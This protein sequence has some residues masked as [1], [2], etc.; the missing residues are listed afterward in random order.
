MP[1]YVCS[2]YM[3]LHKH[4][5]CVTSEMHRKMMAMNMVL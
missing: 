3:Y 5:L 1:N 2:L 4:H